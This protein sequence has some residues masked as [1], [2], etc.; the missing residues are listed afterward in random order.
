[1][2]TSATTEDRLISTPSGGHVEFQVEGTGP[3]ILMI[4]SLGRG[5][6]DFD[7]LSRRLVAAGFAAVRLESRGIGK[8]AGPM[9]NITLHDL[10]SDAA[11][12]IEA[13]GGKPRIGIGPTVGQRVGPTLAPD[14]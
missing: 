11:A 3:A 4:P 5:A 7:D 6:S 2:A 14:R 13:I 1:M 8:T 9:N 10:A 12:V